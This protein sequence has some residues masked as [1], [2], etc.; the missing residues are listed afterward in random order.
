MARYARLMAPGASQVS[1]T[2]PVGRL[3]QLEGWE[4]RR[5]WSRRDGA[6]DGVD[7]QIEPFENELTEQRLTTRRSHQA[8]S[9]H[10]SIS[11]RKGQ[12]TGA[13]QLDLFLVGERDDDLAV[14]WQ[15]QRLDDVLRQQR[16]D[17]SRVDESV[18]LHATDPGAVQVA[19]FG[20]DTVALILENQPCADFAHL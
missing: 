1:C 16:H 19:R 15:S 8:V 5:F 6:F 7:D 18:E 13:W 4:K 17:G 9:I 12:Q 20:E 2:F 14:E 3:L 10:L 11:E